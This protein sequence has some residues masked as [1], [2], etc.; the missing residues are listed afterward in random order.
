[1]RTDKKG[2]VIT[3][4]YGSILSSAFRAAAAALSLILVTLVFLMSYQYAGSVAAD[5]SPVYSESVTTV[6]ID[7]GHGGEDGGAVS[8][9]GHLEKDLNLSV[10]MLLGKSL[11]EMGYNVV[12]T[13]TE[14]KLL[15]S[16]EENIKGM[17]KIY[18]LKNRVKIAES[19]PDAIFVSIHMNAFSSSKYSG[20][21]VYYSP[22]CENSRLL[23]ECVQKEAI[24]QIQ[25]DNTRKIKKAD[26][27]IYILKNINN[28]SIL[29]ECGFMSNPEESRLLADKD[30]QKRLSFA[31][32]CGIIN[33]ENTLRGV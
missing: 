6:I 17:R 31:F 24:E 10:A 25:P 32:V 22:N 7:A 5:V 23:G 8:A 20:L 4:G 33:Y 30:Y 28:P 29:I 15:Y 27:S 9:D 16:E 1:M 13:R 3:C 12:Y 26:D 18:D 14:D 19:H 21:Q 2:A 11:T